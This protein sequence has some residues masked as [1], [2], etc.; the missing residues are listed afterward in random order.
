MIAE[1]LLVLPLYLALFFIW[2]QFRHL[3]KI[4]ADVENILNDVVDTPKEATEQN[5][6]T[7]RI[8]ECLRQEQVAFIRV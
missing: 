6:K 1:L 5:K 2:Y 7:R 4:M 8:K 3:I